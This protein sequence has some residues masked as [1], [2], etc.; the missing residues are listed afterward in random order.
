MYRNATSVLIALQEGRTTVKSCRNQLSK[1]RSKN[2]VDA[3]LMYLTA[4]ELFRFYPDEGS[5]PSRYL[6]I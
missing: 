6:H 2:N 1:A 4:I 3:S 5:T